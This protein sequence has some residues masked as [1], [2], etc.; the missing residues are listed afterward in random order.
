[1]RNGHFIP[2]WPPEACPNGI[3]SALGRLGK[4]LLLN[5]HEVF[6]VAGDGRTFLE[7]QEISV[8]QQV[9]GETSTSLLEKLYD[10]LDSQGA[11]F[12][13]I[14]K[15]CR[16][17]RAAG[18]HCALASWHAHAIAACC[19]ALRGLVHRFATNLTSQGPHP[20]INAASRA[21]K[22]RSAAHNQL[23]ID[24]VSPARGLR[25]RVDSNRG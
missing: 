22:A 9:W 17:R 10:K 25:L 4:Q 18:V 6:Y 14:K 19:V 20:G 5:G 21:E 3:A 11:I 15:A 24:S 8:G 2:G 13:G 1:M 12:S 23:S 16:M 7:D